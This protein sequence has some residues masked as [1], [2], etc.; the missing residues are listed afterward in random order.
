MALQTGEKAAMIITSILVLGMI[1]LGISYETPSRESMGGSG[2]D[3]ESA[4][5]SVD[6]RIHL[7]PAGIIAEQLPE[8]DSPGARALAL[9]CV[10]CHDLPPPAMHEAGQWDAVLGRMKQHMNDRQ[11]GMLVRLVRPSD[12]SWQELAGYLK[13]HALRPLDSARV[14]TANPLAEEF[15]RFCIQC[16]ALPDPTLHSAGEWPRVVVRMKS[17]MQTNA[18][19]QP[20]D[21]ETD[22]II[23]FLMQHASN[24]NGGP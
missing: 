13:R 11:G 22:R 7:I 18:K 5:G 16:H 24:D 2:A 3:R 1:V 6:P 23:S 12:K 15:G 20:S 4:A 19:A 9:Y 17:Y 21:P 8:S 10:Q 14:D